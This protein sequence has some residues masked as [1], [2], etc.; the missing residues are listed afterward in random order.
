MSITVVSVQTISLRLWNILRYLHYQFTVIK[1]YNDIHVYTTYI[2]IFSG[3]NNHWKLYQ[4]TYFL[5]RENPT[6]NK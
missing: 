1:S 5:R 4:R 2:Q 6:N 3:N